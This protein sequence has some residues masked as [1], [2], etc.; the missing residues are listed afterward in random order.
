MTHG[1]WKASSTIANID[2]EPIE[3]ARVKMIAP[4]SASKPPLVVLACLRTKS[5][6]VS[7]RQSAGELRQK[8]DGSRRTRFSS[9]EAFRVD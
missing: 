2:L 3:M 7:S 5:V 9:K 1:G 8:V 4:N 6:L